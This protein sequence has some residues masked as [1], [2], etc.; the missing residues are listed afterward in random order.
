MQLQKIEGCF[1]KTLNTCI[2]HLPQKAPGA[3]LYAICTLLVQYLY[4]YKAYIYC[5]STVQ[6]LYN[7]RRGRLGKRTLPAVG[8][9]DAKCSAL[10][11]TECS[12]KAG[13]AYAIHVQAADNQ[14]REC[15][16]FNIAQK[17]KKKT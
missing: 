17:L 6:V 2:L 10:T 14:Q 4:V 8:K 7:G 12:Q 16:F 1:F 11:A 13:K 9:V 3:P 5:T 15:F